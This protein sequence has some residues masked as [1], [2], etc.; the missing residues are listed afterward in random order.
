MNSS[1]CKLHPNRDAHM[2]RSVEPAGKLILGHLE[3][4]PAFCSFGAVSAHSEALPADGD[5]IVSDREVI[6]IN[7]G[8]AA[9]SPVQ[10]N[11]RLDTYDRGSIHR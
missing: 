10:V 9:F 7:L 3:L 11:E 2:Y 8:A 4:C 6:F 5:A 1:D